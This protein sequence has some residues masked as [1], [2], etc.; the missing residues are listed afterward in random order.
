[1]ILYVSLKIKQNWM[2]IFLF[3]KVQ[4]SHFIH[5]DTNTAIIRGDI[6]NTD[7]FVVFLLGSA[8]S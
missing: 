6:G 2:R 1:M 5:S 4:I 8:V 3:L 7:I